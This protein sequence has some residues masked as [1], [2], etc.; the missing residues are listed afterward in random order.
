MNETALRRPAAGSI[1]KTHMK[2]ALD[3]GTAS[4][5]RIGLVV[6]ATDHTIEAEWRHVIR[7]PGVAIYESRISNSAEINPATLAAME[8]DLGKAASL[9]LP[10]TSLDVIGYGC[11]SASVVLGEE[12]VARRIQ[13]ARPGVAVTNPITAAIAGM[14]TL[15]ARRIALL[16]PYIEEVN[17]RFRSYIEARGLEVPVM[18]SFNHENDNEVACIS[19]AS[20]RDAMI[21][22]GREPAV[23]GIFVSCTSLRVADIAEEVE[24]ATGKPVTSSNLALAWHCLR[25]AGVDDSISGFGRLFRSQL[26]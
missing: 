5:C 23:D 20:I 18:G 8:K 19:T 24:Q 9:I 16:T 2:F 21:E 10:G 7:L 26:G 15:G 25:L 13:E 1:S 14:K 12:T 3:G 4:R 22:L 6:L 17:Q 11:T